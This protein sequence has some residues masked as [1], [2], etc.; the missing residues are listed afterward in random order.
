MSLNKLSISM[1]AA[2]FLSSCGGMESTNNDG[3]DKEAALGVM[4]KYAEATSCMHSFNKEEAQ[5]ALTSIDD[6]YLVDSNDEAGT[7]GYYVF[8]SGDVGCNGG[9]GTF[10]YQLSEVS[11]YLGASPLLVHNVSILDD[12]NINARFIESVKQISKDEFEIIAGEMSDMGNY[13]DYKFKYTLERK[14]GLWEITNKK[15]LQQ[16]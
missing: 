5:G 14:E 4:K 15:P 3:L 8:W 13:A 16:Y 6:V 10:S 12:L 2:L 9:S 11:Q 1:F 7:V